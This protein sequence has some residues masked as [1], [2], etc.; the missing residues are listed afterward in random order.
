M[1]FAARGM[2]L[3]YV[4]VLLTCSV[5]SAE[6]AVSAN[7]AK[8]KLTDG[9]VSVDSNR[10]SDNIA[11][12][13]MQGPMPKVIATVDNVPT[14][15]VGPPSSVAITP[16]EGLALV[17]A[18]TKIDPNDSTKT[19]S[20][21]TLT[22]IDLKASPPAVIAKL[23]KT[24]NQV[25]AEPAVRE[26]LTAAGVIVQGGSPEAFGQMMD[27]ELARWDAVRKAAGLEQR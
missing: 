19:T 2:L 3:L 12:L 4:S 1:T 7:D 27:R 21:N 5:A 23:N 6:I 9:V 13:D 24:L 20:D 25:I 8:P 22:V 16:D 15:V 10:G 26:R 14:S 11:I 17:S 18:S